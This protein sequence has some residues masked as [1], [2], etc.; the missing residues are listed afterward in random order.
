MEKSGGLSDVSLVVRLREGLFHMPASEKNVVAGNQRRFEEDC[1]ESDVSPCGS[2]V[3]GCSSK[4]K[5][6]IWDLSGNKL[7]EEVFADVANV[8]F[9][10][11]SRFAVVTHGASKDTRIRVYRLGTKEVAVRDQTFDVDIGFMKSG[12]RYTYFCA[13]EGLMVVQKAPNLLQVF[14]V[15]AGFSSLG[16]MEIVPSGEIGTILN[17]TAPFVFA[18]NASSVKEGKKGTLFEIYNVETLKL[19][20]SHFF[21]GLQQVDVFPSPVNNQILIRG[22]KH[23][24]DSGQSY[25][26]K[27][28]LQLM[29]VDKKA[30]VNLQF[31]NGPVYNVAWNPRGDTFA[32]CVGFMPAYTVIYSSSGDPQ[33][34]VERSYKNSVYWSPNGDFLAVAG[35][36]NLSGEI[37]IWNV[38]KR[39]KIGKCMH[40]DAG[41]LEWAPDGRHFVTKVEFRFLREGNQYRVYDYHGTMLTKVELN[42]TQLQSVRWYPKGVLVDR[43]PSPPPPKPASKLGGGPGNNLTDIASACHL[44]KLEDIIKANGS[45]DRS[46]LA[47]AKQPDA[48]KPQKIPGQHTPEKEKKKK[49]KKK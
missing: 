36:G 11:M 25:Y 15:K 40:G 46:E 6:T 34:V 13:E 30:I 35:F 17:G 47:K 22:H 23:V 10:R 9:S 21:A 44:I 31:Y 41:D 28:T 19:H 8:S 32:V 16:T 27:N 48:D 45:N 14:A 20:H 49:K 43:P 7:V 33:M 3:I 5:V 29:N 39:A 4:G 1:V 2:F 24:D 42:T 18:S 26:G 38:P 12:K 37:S